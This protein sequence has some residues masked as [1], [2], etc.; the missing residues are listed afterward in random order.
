MPRLDLSL[1]GRSFPVQCEPGEEARAEA[2]AGYVDGRLRQLSAAQSSAT[3]NRLLMLGCLL[4]A[5]EIFELKGQGKDGGKDSGK[6]SAPI[7]SAAPEGELENL[8]V[9][10]VDDL[11]GKLD[12]LA[13]RLE[14]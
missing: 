12:R 11:R 3:E 8:L 6:S 10:A 2:L 1:L 4:L 9:A 14:I 7:L 5:D 13:Q